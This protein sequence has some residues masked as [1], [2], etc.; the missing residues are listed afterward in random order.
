VTQ[1]AA[2][3]LDR[4]GTLNRLVVDPESGLPESPLHVADVQLIEGAA[5]AVRAL[6]SAGF[7][8]VCVTNQPAAAKGKAT[9]E[10]LIAI[11]ERVLELLRAEGAAWDASKVCLHH[12]DSVVA[13]LAGRCDCR[14][15]APGM[16]LEAAA[17]LDLDLGSSWILGDS[18]ADVGAGRAAGT[19]TVL[20][21]QP[22]SAHRRRGGADADF[23]ADDLKQAVSHVMAARLA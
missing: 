20:I 9:V 13:D 4:D 22:E 23:V 14:K 10:Q 3:F 11:H 18:D 7:V 21:D 16:L 12:P 19:R 17:E 5:A 15:P 6:A 2:A 8:V 1:R